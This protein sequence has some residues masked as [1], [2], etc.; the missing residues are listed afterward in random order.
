[1]WLFIH[2]P[3]LQ[4][5][6]SDIQSADEI[7]DQ[8]FMT[9]VEVIEFGA[10]LA[11]SRNTIKWAWLFKTYLQWHAVA[12]V[13]SELC[14]RPL[15]RDF[16]RA[17]NAV[18]S[19]YDRQMIEQTKGHR[20]VLW[21]P[22]KQLYARA[23]KRRL[24]LTGKSPTSSNSNTMTPSDS[25]AQNMLNG[26]PQNNNNFNTNPYTS[27]LASAADT[28]ELD[29]NDPVFADMVTGYGNEMNVSDFTTRGQQPNQVAFQPV[30]QLPFGFQT[31]IDFLGDYGGFPPQQNFGQPMP[32]EWH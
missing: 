27:N 20:G 16:E 12:Y 23:N 1:M 3:R 11:R 31:G 15:G 18:D 13:L 14:T 10:L 30:D 7:R 8:V 25:P 9:T 6:P 28:F 19:L 24:E 5:Q 29:F 22:L 26:F 2:H 17:W 32:Q 21:R 4:Q